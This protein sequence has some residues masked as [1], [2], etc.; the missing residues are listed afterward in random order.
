ML[1]TL[2]ILY[3]I[4]LPVSIYL[5]RV[6]RKTAETHKVDGETVSDLETGSMFLVIWLISPLFLAILLVATLVRYVGRFL[7]PSTV[8]V[9]Q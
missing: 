4:G 6:G 7:A 2:C 8:P 1:I 3:A 9:D 5:T